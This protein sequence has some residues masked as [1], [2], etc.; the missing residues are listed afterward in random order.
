MFEQTRERAAEIGLPLVL[1]EPW[2]DVDDVS[3][4]RRLREELLPS[5]PQVQTSP[6][7]AARHARAA[8]A[9]MLQAQGLAQRLADPKPVAG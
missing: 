4:L 5:S 9:R 7:H 3:A 1:L 8:L 6:I 2:Y